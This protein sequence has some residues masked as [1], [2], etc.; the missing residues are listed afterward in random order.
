MSLHFLEVTAEG[1]GAAGVE[2]DSRDREEGGALI[3]IHR[4][5][6]KT[7]RVRQR[8]LPSIVASTAPPGQNSIMIWGKKGRREKR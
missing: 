1:T 5:Q 6:K 3:K 7:K 4:E 2:L 8:G